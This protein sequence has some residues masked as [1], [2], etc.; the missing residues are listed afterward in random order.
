LER[1]ALEL[2]LVVFVPRLLL[3]VVNEAP[4]PS[5]PK[6]FEDVFCF[7]VDLL[8]LV[9]VLVCD[10]NNDNLVFSNARRKNKAFLNLATKN[11]CK[12]IVKIVCSLDPSDK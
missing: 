12:I 4:N 11:Q 5:C 3:G 1:N 2:V 9:F 7:L 10:R 6:I 8:V